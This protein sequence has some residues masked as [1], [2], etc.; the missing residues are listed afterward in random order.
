MKNLPPKVTFYA[1]ITSLLLTVASVGYSQTLT[2]RYSFNDPTTVID[3]VGGPNWNGTLL[4]SAT[5][6]GSNLQLDGGGWV[7]L[8]SGII[9]NYP[10]VSVEF[11]VTYSPDNPVWTRTFA[12]GDQ[13]NGGEHTGVDYTHYAGGNYQNLNISTEANGGAYANNPAGLNGQTNVHVT[14][15]VDPA[16]NRMYYYN[17]LTSPSV[18][19]SSTVPPLSG[20]IDSVNLIGK[21]LWDQDAPLMGTINEFRV[22]NG[23]ITPAQLALNDAAGPDNYVTNP[24]SLLAVHLNS[25]D[26]PLLAN[27][28][29]QQ[30]FTG[31]FA[32]V[33]GV[34]LGVY[35]GA[36][37]TSGNTGIL[38]V[39]SSNGLVRAVSAGTTT[40]IASFGGR[41][42]TNTLTVLSV[43]AVL[44]H[45]YSFTSDAN[46]SVGGA[47][48]TLANGATV[49]GGKAVLDGNAAYVDLPGNLINISSNKA[50]TFDTWVTIGDAQTWSRLL[51]FG[52]DGGS[53]E[54]WFGPRAFGNGGE[55]TLSENIPGGVTIN[56]PGTLT[57][58]TTHLT[59]VIDPPTSTLAIY[60]DGILDHAR[61]DASAALSLVSTQMAVL[62]RSLVAV[63]PY[64]P[65][66][67]DEFRIY[68][69]ALTPQE[70]A[71]SQTNGPNSV[72]HDPGALLSVTVPPHVYPA[73]SSVVPPIIL[74]NYA[75]LTGFNLLPNNSASVAGLTLT[76]SDPSVLQVLGNNMLKTFRPGTVT[77]TA[78]YLGKT[79]SATVSVGNVAQLTHRYTFNTDASDSVGGA[80]GALQGTATVTGGE[81]VLDGNPGSYVELPP[82]LLS[83]YDAA[84]IDTWV[85]FGA[86]QTWA[87]LWY[88]GND[89]VDEFYVA[90]SVNNG[91][92]H[93]FSTGFPV[94]GA[95]ITIPPRWENQT[96]HIT[97]VYGNGTMEYYTN[98]VLHGALSD[99]AGTMAEV[100]NWFS[101]IGRSPY[102]DP[103]VIANV[104]EFRIYRGRLSPDEIK[105]SD[106]IGANQLLT[107]N[108]PMTITRSPG[109]IT[110]SWPV[111]AGGFSVQ[112]EPA[113]N[114]SWSTLSTTPTLAG[115]QWQVT[116]P[117]S[118]SAQFFR[119]VR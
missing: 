42:V 55:H 77:L 107:T 29:S 36:T 23:A 50:V 57:N 58:L 6:D 19:N 30:L 3:S 24:G 61:Y 104:D 25:P 35:G 66:S 18:L 106:V 72:A 59:F 94:G 86:A 26:N 109:S 90:P 111:A 81:L 44:T 101:W 69:G 73:Y 105:A 114:G 67:I 117:T 43:P 63:D 70:I 47:N 113:L 34:N 49:A 56:W 16:G 88:F 17:G 83:G 76:S 85:T 95:T 22:Y 4:G 65:G 60:R 92:A 93:W 2:H 48:G 62:G 87:R 98:G 118:G 100:G 13:I 75:N 37:F 108:A 7:I 32:N 89:R 99:L 74:A 84:T 82:G 64:L 40:L 53:S 15:V 33:T 14:V 8:P 5:L 31:D 115:N 54:V 27:Q 12:F 79:G 41:S 112:S 51:D 9:T 45:R 38:T 10:Q 46:D 1:G 116:V 78:T 102:A 20:V 11:W 110:I 91:D 39:N 103:Y 80:N 68:S 28:N 52:A 119:L 21:S 71:L 96:L 97:C